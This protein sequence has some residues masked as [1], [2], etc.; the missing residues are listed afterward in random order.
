VPRNPQPALEGETEREYAWRIYPDDARELLLAKAAPARRCAQT[1][2]GAPIW[3]GF[4]RANNRRCPFDI[5]PD[6]TRTGT[7]HWRTC[8]DRPRKDNH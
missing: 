6:G 7:S 4:T 3:W 5:K 2:C 8:R 1:G